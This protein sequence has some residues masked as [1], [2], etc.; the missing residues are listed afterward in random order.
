M[1]AILRL[2]FQKF[3][4]FSHSFDIMVDTS[5][6]D[7][8][9]LLILPGIF[10]VSFS[11]LMLQVTITRI[12]S[13]TL[14]YHYAFVAVSVAL[15]GWGLGGIFLHFRGQQT[16]DKSISTAALSSLVFAFSIQACLWIVV[17]LSLPIS[18]FVIYYTLSMIPFFVGGFSSALLFRAR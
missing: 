14:W 4:I 7:R 5:S 16:D 1:R 12:F 17:R 9:L 3:Y 2:C 6:R 11:S 8:A 18:Y 10:L 13:V 15:F